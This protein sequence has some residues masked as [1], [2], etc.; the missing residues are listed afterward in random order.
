MRCIALRRSRR[1]M[2]SRAATMRRR[3]NKEVEVTFR[4]RQGQKLTRSLPRRKTYTGVYNEEEE[5][6]YVEEDGILRH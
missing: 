5:A 3:I 4:C 6:P 1:K 2:V